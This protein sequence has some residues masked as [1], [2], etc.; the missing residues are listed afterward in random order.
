M[1]RAEHEIKLLSESK[2]NKKIQYKI[3]VWHHNINQVGSKF[4]YLTNWHE[5]QMYVFNQFHYQLALHGHIH[6]PEDRF[7]PP[8]FKQ[9]EKGY[10][11][12]AGAISVKVDER[13]KDNRSVANLSY[14]IIQLG[15]DQDYQQ[16]R[17][18]LREASGNP[19]EPLEWDTVKDVPYK[20]VDKTS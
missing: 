9:G 11:F 4:D 2:P 16:L 14:N 10:V 8:E 5:V 15:G 7:N 19:G 3:A 1:I 6:H 13:S 12:G 20:L 17:Y 18:I